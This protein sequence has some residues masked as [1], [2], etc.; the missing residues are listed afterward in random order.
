MNNDTIKPKDKEAANKM[1]IGLYLLTR[2]GGSLRSRPK[3]I[4]PVLINLDSPSLKMLETDIKTYY[5]ARGYTQSLDT[6]IDLAL[7][8][9][10]QYSFEKEDEKVTVASEIYSILE[11]TSSDF[12]RLQETSRASIS[13]IALKDDEVKIK[14]YKPNPNKYYSN[15]IIDS[16]ISSTAAIC[17]GIL[18][19]IALTTAGMYVNGS[20]GGDLFKFGIIYG[21][22]GGPLTAV[23]LRSDFVD[24]MSNLKTIKKN[25]AVLK[26]LESDKEPKNKE[27]SFLEK[28]FHPFRYRKLKKFEKKMSLEIKLENKVGDI[29]ED[30]TEDATKD[31]TTKTIESTSDNASDPLNEEDSPQD[32]DSRLHQDYLFSQKLHRAYLFAQEKGKISPQHITYLVTQKVNNPYREWKYSYR[33]STMVDGKMIRLGES[34]SGKFLNEFLQDQVATRDSSEVEYS[35]ENNSNLWGISNHHTC[36]IAVTSNKRRHIIMIEEKGKKIY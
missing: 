8:N 32:I 5:L 14:H 9:T 10:M 29:N 11:T 26:L 21:S 18:P 28:I 3:E 27:V 33:L 23:V 34:I 6:K 7:S 20:L 30:V 1:D 4:A 35:S 2:H 12:L 16:V 13:L 19:S 15:K 25:N 22:I 31:T 36:Y 17:F 24:I